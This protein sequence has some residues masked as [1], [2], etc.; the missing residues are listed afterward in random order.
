MKTA[1]RIA[2]GLIIAGF[3]MLCQPFTHLLFVW[4]FPVLLCGT[5]LFM[6]LDHIPAQRP[7]KEEGHG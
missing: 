6:T 7:N 1:Y 3:V 5:I 2:S 4:G